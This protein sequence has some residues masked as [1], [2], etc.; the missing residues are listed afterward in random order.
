M[1]GV[2]DTL[3]NYYDK[4]IFFFIDVFASV[5]SFFVAILDT[6]ENYY[7]TVH[8]FITN[9]FESLRSWVTDIPIW[10]LKKGFEA[11]LWVLNWAAESCSYCLGGVFHAGEL[12][13]KFQWAWNTIATYSPGLIYVVN[14]CGVPEAFKILVCGMGIWAVVKTIMVIKGIL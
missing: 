12:A 8:T 3:T 1:Q 9:G 13:D 5:K 14:R 4:F 11:L 2:I 10:L 6:I 7:D